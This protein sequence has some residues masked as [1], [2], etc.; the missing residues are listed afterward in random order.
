MQRLFL[1]WGASGVHKM[2][3]KKWLDESNKKRKQK[4]AGWVAYLGQKQMKRAYNFKYN[5]RTVNYRA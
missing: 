5:K 1:Q 4:K 3:K 2:G